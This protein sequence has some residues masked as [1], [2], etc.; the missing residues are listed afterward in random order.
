MVLFSTPIKLSLEELY[1]IVD[2]TPLIT[3]YCN[4][5]EGTD[6]EQ[7]VSIIKDYLKINYENN[8]IGARMINTLVHQYFINGSLPEKIVKQSTFQNKI[9]L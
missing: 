8:T 7:V 5:V 2:R 1:G 3:Q 9:V 6:K 4:L